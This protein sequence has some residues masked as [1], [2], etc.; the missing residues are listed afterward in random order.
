M[1]LRVARRPNSDIRWPSIITASQSSTTTASVFICTAILQSL[2]ERGVA[3]QVYGYKW[4]LAGLGFIC[5]GFTMINV[6]TRVW[7]TRR[8]K[9]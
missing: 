7:R 3:C 2:K 1:L 9:S 5:A 8:G 6:T 4:N